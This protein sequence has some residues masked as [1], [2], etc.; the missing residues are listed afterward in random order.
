[1]KVLKK[2]S[3][4]I[5]VADTGIGMTGEDIAKALEPYEQADSI[6]SR[7]HEGTG[8]GLYICRKHMEMHGGTLTIKSKVGMGTTVRGRF[9]PERTIHPS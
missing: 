9:P 1:M 5:S 2:G 7:K 8:L 6:H 3:I 4:V